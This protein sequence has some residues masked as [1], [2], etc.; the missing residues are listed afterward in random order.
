MTLPDLSRLSLLVDDI[1]AGKRHLDAAAAR[2]NETLLKRQK[3]GGFKVSFTIMYP[4][5]TH[6]TSAAMHHLRMHVDD[7]RVAF[8][9]F[10]ATD[11]T[12]NQWLT[13]LNIDLYGR[14]NH[15]DAHSMNLDP[16]S[17]SATLLCSSKGIMLNVKHADKYTSSTYK[18]LRGSQYANLLAYLSQDDDV[19]RFIQ[20]MA[21]NW[22]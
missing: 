11:V 5:R 22:P 12:P 14:F 7:V 9:A 6:T 4:R 15:I 3:L 2:D 16:K 20:D 19:K 18:V 21:P 1:A 8:V 10:G 13:Q 17:D